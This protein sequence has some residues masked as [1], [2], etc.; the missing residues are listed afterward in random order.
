MAQIIDIA[1]AVVA[2]LNDQ[3]S[4]QPFTATRAYRASFDLRELRNKHLTIV[5]KWWD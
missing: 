4:S 3:I 2:A 1:D 5:P